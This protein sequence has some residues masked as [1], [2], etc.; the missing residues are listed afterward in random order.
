M[1]VNVSGST[2]TLS[3]Q[4]AEEI[5]ALLA[6]KRRS[7][8][9]LATEIG[10]NQTWVSSRLTGATPIGLND[11]QKIAAAL[12]IDVVEL[13]QRARTG[14]VVNTSAG[15][16]QTTGP[17]VEQPKRPMLTGQSK[18]TMPPPSSRRPA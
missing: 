17:N 13:I 12:E 2:T 15:T 9:W 3:A 6:R 18:R 1:T 14:A 8:R 10:E 5:R 11:L 16:G 4:V 7:G